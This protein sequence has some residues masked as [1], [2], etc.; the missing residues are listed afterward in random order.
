[1]HMKAAKRVTRY[2]KGTLD[3]GDKFYKS[4]NF[5]LQGY[6]DSNW[7]GSTDDMKNTLGYCFNLGSTYFS[8]GIVPQSTAKVGL[9]IA[10]TTIYQV[11][12]LRKI[13]LDLDLEQQGKT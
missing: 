1:M 10:T 5:K 12:W 7:A 3:C 9:I 4:Q 8:L 2:V 11:L 13:M 6:S